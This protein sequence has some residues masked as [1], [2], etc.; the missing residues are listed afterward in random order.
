MQSRVYTITER[1]RDKKSLEGFIRKPRGLVPL[2]S[3]S[4][5]VISRLPKRWYLGYAIDLP[6]PPVSYPGPEL[7]ILGPKLLR[8]SALS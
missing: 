5:V 3:L 2:G 6:N 4:F 7:P 1:E 8:P